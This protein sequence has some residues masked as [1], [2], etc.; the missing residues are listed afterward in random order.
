[1]Q[2]LRSLGNARISLR[3]PSENASGALK[4]SGGGEDREIKKPDNPNLPLK[5]NKKNAVDIIKVEDDAPPPLQNV[6]DE[7]T[8]SKRDKLLYKAYVEFACLCDVRISKLKIV[9]NEQSGVD[10]KEREYHTPFANNKQLNTEDLTLVTLNADLQRVVE[11]TWIDIEDCCSIKSNGITLEWFL[12][13][14]NR[15]LLKHKMFVK[16]VTLRVKIKKLEEQDV[17]NNG[18]AN[19][20]NK[21]I[22]DQ[23]QL[24][25]N[26]ILYW[27]KHSCK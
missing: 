14:K 16:L 19:Y 4:H 21:R 1:M 24:Q 15:H 11:Q 6:I 7:S 2:V 23:C 22:W 20:L 8:L 27:F 9:P 13:A 12:N 26:Q 3:P 10:K 18:G 25:N 17:H 5:S